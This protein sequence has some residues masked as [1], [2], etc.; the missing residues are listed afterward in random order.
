MTDLEFRICVAV[1]LLAFAVAGGA[2]GHL[3]WEF[4][5]WRRLRR[6]QKRGGLL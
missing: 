1:A 2:I 4:R 3:D 6:C 5:R